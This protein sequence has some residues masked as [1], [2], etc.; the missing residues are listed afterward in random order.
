MP[1]QKEFEGKKLYRSQSNRMIAGVCGG[2]A[3]YFNIDPTLVRIIV[4]AIAL[5]GGVGILAYI[6]AIVIVPSNPETTSTAGGE[7]IIKDKSLFWGSLLIILGVFFLLRQTGIWYGFE[8]WRIP[9]QMVWAFFLIAV[10]VYM[11]YNRK[12][13]EENEDGSEGKSFTAGKKL[14]RSKDQK[15]LAGVCGGI[16]EY[17]DMDVSIV[18]ILWAIVTIASAGIGLLVYILMVI[19][20]PE[21]PDDVEDKEI[22]V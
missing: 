13:T 17:F 14:Y 21:T 22:S 11:L 18:R 8:F 6:A 20:F 16:A 15:M 12:H 10:G 4:I 9:W 19:I 5:F 2:I 1:T 7:P 3:E